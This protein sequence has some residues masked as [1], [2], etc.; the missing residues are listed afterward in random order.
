[1]SEPIDKMK[2]TTRQSLD[3]ELELEKLRL[4]AQFRVES[5]KADVRKVV[6]GTMIVGLAAAFFPFAQEL[7]KSW[8]AKSVEE[9][10]REAEFSILQ[11]KNRLAKDLETQKFQL[12]AS[13]QAASN[14]SARRDYLEHLADEARSERIERQ[15]ITAEF[16]S[17]LG[18]EKM[19]PQWEGFRDYL[20]AK[21]QRLNTERSQL[22]A[23][24]NETATSPSDRQSAAER[25]RQIERLQNPEDPRTNFNLSIPPASPAQSQLGRTMLQIAINE[26]NSGVHEVRQPSRIAEYW[27]SI[28]LNITGLDRDI[29]WSAAFVS[30]VI[31]E[32]GNPHK[33]KLSSSHSLIWRD[34]KERGLT[35][36]PTDTSPLPGDIA[37]RM[38]RESDVDS[39]IGG[40]G[41]APSF[42]GFVHEVNAD[43][44]IVIGGNAK[45][46][47]RPTSWD[48]ND[49]RIVGF[50][51]LP[52]LSAKE[53]K[54]IDL[55]NEEP[56]VGHSSE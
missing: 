2:D 56:D 35:L 51:R 45:N 38:Q 44:I 53:L 17:F 39:W 10:R 29:P 1:M 14:V 43:E 5:M 4:D 24:V 32:A 7:A 40:T 55:G 33:L 48:R 8:F 50:I 30:W 11:E 25:L 54:R 3:Q 49:P 20:I 28:G 42:S 41:F 9:I 18:E 13:Q 52:D 34:A 15:I 19:R 37:V 23:T 46:S 27:S 6:F 16:F 31:K 36:S 47:V 21:Q 12:E 26:A 22:L